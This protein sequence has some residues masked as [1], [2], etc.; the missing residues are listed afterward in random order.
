MDPHEN[1]SQPLSNPAVSLAQ[2]SKNM[3]RG[4]GSSS[5]LPASQDPRFG[6]STYNYSAQQDHP[7]QHQQRDSPSPWNHHL[8][9]SSGMDAYESSRYYWQPEG[10]NVKSILDGSYSRTVQT[11]D[12]GSFTAA[13]PIGL[14][15]QPPYLL[16]Q[17]AVEIS[18]MRESELY[19]HCPPSVHSNPPL[20]FQP[21]PPPDSY[22][23]PQMMGPVPFP[24]YSNEGTALSLTND[25]FHPNAFTHAPNMVGINR[26]VDPS[27]WQSSTV[28]GQQSPGMA[29]PPGLHGSDPNHMM[30]NYNATRDPAFDTGGAE[31][32][33][34]Q[35]QLQQ[36]EFVQND[37]PVYPEDQEDDPAEPFPA[38]DRTWTGQSAE[39]IIDLDKRRPDESARD[40]DVQ[41]DEAAQT[42]DS[43]PEQSELAQ[44]PETIQVA[45][46]KVRGDSPTRTGSHEIPTS[47]GRSVGRPHAIYQGETTAS[48]VSEGGSEVPDGHA[49]ATET[50][51]RNMDFRV[52]D[53]T[54]NTAAINLSDSPDFRSEERIAA[55]SAEES[56]SL[57]TDETWQ[58]VKRRHTDG[59][60][61]TAGQS[62]LLAEGA[63]ES[64][65][66]GGVSVRTDN[67][68]FTSIQSL[69]NSFAFGRRR[70]NR[71]GKPTKWGP[72]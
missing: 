63:A 54:T 41:T 65:E 31:T 52:Y 28:Q 23:F 12:Q 3:S 24:V 67:R 15:I 49:D 25:S 22:P 1:T 59:K 30:Q 21:V 4:L 69:G 60:S 51:G 32:A 48:P 68:N 27:A 35:I 38:P 47:G 2:V 70:T 58:T 29:P 33:L 18:M 40:D 10:T 43:L 42:R 55:S 7:Q 6:L 11:A 46:P 20:D 62:S 57:Q 8:P 50:L 39:D 64:R 66:R 26:E 34:Y 72:W 19:M 17:P 44:R 56:V 53:V 37:P 14:G 36:R 61:R 5:G 9:P 13:P 71:Q 16:Q 45:I